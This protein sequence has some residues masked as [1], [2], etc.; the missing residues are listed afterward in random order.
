MVRI[1]D[2]FSDRLRLALSRLG[3]SS[4]S[5]D[6]VCRLRK[7]FADVGVPSVLI[8][9]GVP[10]FFSGHFAQ[11]CQL[12][13]VDD[14]KSTP[15]YLKSNGHA[16]SAIKVV[17]YLIL[18]TTKNGALDRYAFQRGLLQWRNSPRESGHSPAHILFN[19]MS[20]I[21]QEGHVMFTI[22]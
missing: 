16:E 9:D 20:H 2:F 13:N 22:S 12:W 6:V 1:P 14:R 19:I 5:Q 18:K 4:F 8:M 17:K 7:W 3:H 21:F 15:Q 11:F 10:Q